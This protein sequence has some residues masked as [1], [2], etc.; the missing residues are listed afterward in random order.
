[1]SARS[2]D[3][4]RGGTKGALRHGMGLVQGVYL[5]H[6]ST[7]ALVS[8]LWCVLLPNRFFKHEGEWKDGLKQG[9]LQVIHY[10]INGPPLEEKKNN[11]KN[12]TYLLVASLLML[13]L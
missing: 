6:D 8:R 12:S 10:L 11:K 7:V 2:A 5:N 13:S 9:E 4:Y 3:S 1:M